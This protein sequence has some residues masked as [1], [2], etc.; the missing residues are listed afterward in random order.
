MEML[1]KVRRY[2]QL[3]IAIRVHERK[4]QWPQKST[5]ENQDKEQHF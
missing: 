3:L 1:L 2:M 5:K 4:N